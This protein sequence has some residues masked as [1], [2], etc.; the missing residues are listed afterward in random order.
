M[1]ITA[2]GMAENL[3]AALSPRGSVL[4]QRLPKPSIEIF[5]RELHLLNDIPEDSA[6]LQVALPED[7]ARIHDVQALLHKD[8]HHHP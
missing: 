8:I 1:V 7:F 3:F 5:C 2:L 4:R 6:S